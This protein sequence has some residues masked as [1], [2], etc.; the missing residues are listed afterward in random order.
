MK[1]IFIILAVFI[2]TFSVAQ[3]ED[4]NSLL[5]P[6][7]VQPP[8]STYSRSTAV[9]PPTSTKYVFNCK[10]HIVK[11]TNGTGSTANFGESQVLSA[12][13]ILNTN[14]NQFNIYFKY[15]GF[16]VIKNS[17]Y[18]KLN[19]GTGATNIQ[20]GLQTFAQLVA[21]SKTGTAAVYDNFALNLFI[22]D[23]LDQDL[24]TLLPKTNCVA[25]Q[26]GI[27]CAFTNT[28]FLTSSVPHEIGHNFNLYHTHEKHNT[29]QCEHASGDNA[30]TA[31]DLVVDTP[32]SYIFNSGNLSSSCGYINPNNATDCQ[33]T[34]FTNCPVKNFMSTNNL[35]CRQLGANLLPGN[36]QFTNGQANRMRDHIAT[37]IDNTANPIG[38]NKAQNTV[39]SLYEPFVSVGTGGSAGTPMLAASK[40][41]T[42]N[43]NN[44]GANVWN[45]PIYTLRFQTGL[46]YEFSN[47][48]IGVLTKT[49]IEQYNYSFNNNLLN[50][51]IP[52][53]SQDIYQS[54]GINCFSSFEPYTSG[55]VKSMSN[56]GAT[57]Y[58]IEELNAIEASDPE[59]Y[60]TLMSNQYH[61][62][63]KETDSGYIDQKII[64]KN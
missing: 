32:A 53:F 51:K 2:S 14:Y 10:F 57:T 17:L 8:L 13:M 41:Y 26:P 27:D 3:I 6:N 28:A 1:N 63:T 38:Y 56:L 49:P 7:F 9:V 45:C 50:V 18:M 42:P 19:S 31:G 16:D 25:Y 33:G 47:S 22:V 59:L 43:A 46:T 58:T 60:N 11:N 40:T 24:T 64:R 37:Y 48:T 30:A 12:I 34:L 20:P 61:I 15:K 4:C 35:S 5:N 36:A 21:Y 23:M 29:A 44:T 52:A 55:D 39:E 54:G 62:I